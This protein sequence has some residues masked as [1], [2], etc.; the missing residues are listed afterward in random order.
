VEQKKE[1]RMR[2]TWRRGP[3]DLGPQSKPWTLK[4]YAGKTV[5]DWLQLLIVPVMILLITVV[6]T[7]QQNNRQEAIEEQRAQ[8]LTLQN[9]LDQMGSLLLN[10][11]LRASEEGSEVRTLARART[12]T[13]LGRLDPS[14]KTAV[15]QFLVEAELVQRVDGR[16]P[17]IGLSG[18]DLSHTD[19]SHTDLSYADLSGASLS[20]ADLSDANLDNAGLREASLLEANLSDADL[21]RANLSEATTTESPQAILDQAPSHY[22]TNMRNVQRVRSFEDLSEAHLKRPISSYDYEQT[23]PVGGPHADKWQNCG[24]YSKP[25]H[26]E[27]AVHSLE[28]GAVWITYRSDL[29]QDQVGKLQDLAYSQTYILISPSPDLPSP[30]VDSAWGKQMY[31]DGTD[32]PALAHFVRAYR[33]GPQAPEPGAACTNSVGTPE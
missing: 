19:L 9:Y 14:R 28:H 4:E 26:N 16:G 29:S 12:L 30:V 1:A 17:I 23:P 21:F 3:Q 5:W 25:V 7:W 33:Q 32:D 10:G 8:D 6:F 2:S 31:L 22:K 15:M 18:A 11:E 20:Y 13:V 27:N 24:F